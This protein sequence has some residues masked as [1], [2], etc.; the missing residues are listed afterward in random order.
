MR[1]I[2]SCAVIFILSLF[3]LTVY[4]EEEA[5]E[6]FP[7]VGYVKNEEAIVR[8]GDNVNFENLCSLSKSDSVKIIDRRYSW[9]KILLPKKA[10]L[11]VNKD[12]VD[13]T[14]DEK[15]VGIINASNVNLRAGAGTRYSIIGQ[16]SKPEKVSIISEDSGW[17]KIEPPYG[18][19]GWIYSNQIMLA[20]E[21]EIK[22][23]E[24]KSEQKKV[25]AKPKET[26]GST[27]RLNANYPA[28]KGNLSIITPAK[29]SR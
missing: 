1:Y 25:E 28:P 16:I 6:K 7:K 26:T 10:F 22:I 12:Y 4:S 5:K 21:N 23:P 9:F 19:T 15:G 18:A 24:Q 14:S 13:L 29:N 3:S 20:E 2:K 11:Y 27:V 17:Y 8:A